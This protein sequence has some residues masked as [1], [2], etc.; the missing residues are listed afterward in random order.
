MCLVAALDLCLPGGIAGES[1]R[2][3][4][5]KCIAVTERGEMVNAA[6]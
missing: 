5:Q 3:K 6:A 1:L 2:D 4:V